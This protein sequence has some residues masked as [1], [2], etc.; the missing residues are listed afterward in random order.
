M[1]ALLDLASAIREHARVARLSGY[2]S[3]ERDLLQ[4][5]TRLDTSAKRMA[6]LEAERLAAASAPKP[7]RPASRA[8]PW[9]GRA[10]LPARGH[11]GG[12]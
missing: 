2:H 3:V 7:R 1:T 10:V 5:A 9:R 4:A 8:H 6:Q 11:G 12:T